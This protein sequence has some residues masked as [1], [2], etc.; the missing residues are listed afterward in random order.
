M[1]LRRPLAF[2]VLTL[3]G[4]SLLASHAATAQ[5]DTSEGSRKI[6]NRVMP[7]YPQLAHQFNARGN[8]KLEA[9]VGSDGKVK[10]VN[11]K[12]GHPLLV[13]AAQEAIR[14]WRYAPASHE[15]TESIDIN[16]NPQ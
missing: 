6:I 10:S 5:E 4:A 15:T 9:V 16:F 1:S 14:Q 7:V 12:G 11:A 2:A 3:Y 13:E 8:V